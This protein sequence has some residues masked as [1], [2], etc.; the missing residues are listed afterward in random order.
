MTVWLKTIIKSSDHGR[1]SWNSL[2]S[3]FTL[4]NIEVDR[5]KHFI[6]SPNFK[7][8]LNGSRALIEQNDCKIPLS[9]YTVT[10]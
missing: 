7:D 10:I 9:F 8:R 1:A 5:S 3:M 2:D 4:I 6:R